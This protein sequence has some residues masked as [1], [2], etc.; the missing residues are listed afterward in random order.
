MIGDGPDPPVRHRR[1]LLWTRAACAFFA[2][3]ALLAMLGWHRAQGVVQLSL[4]PR[5]PYGSQLS[6]GERHP[7][8]LYSF[9]GYIWQQHQLWPTDGAT[10]GPANLHRLAAFFTPRMRRSLQLRL[11]QRQG[12][13]Q[14]AGRTRHALPSG[15][16]SAA[17]VVREGGGWWVRLEQRVEEQLRGSS[18]RSSAKVYELRVLET[19]LDPETNP[20]KLAIDEVREREA[21]MP[22]AGAD[23]S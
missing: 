9:A 11:Q 15:A 19:D 10:D 8:E 16:Y 12:A 4:P 1:E 22:G 21:G 20:W 6:A 13:G 7:W 17:A 18:V 14:L 23:R 5:I 2:L 3:M